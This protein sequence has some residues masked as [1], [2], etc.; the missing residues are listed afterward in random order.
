MTVQQAFELAARHQRCGQWTEAEALYRQILAVAPSHADSH[1]N[2][3]ILCAGQERLDE[4]VAAFRRAVQIRPDY[5]DAWNNLGGA[6]KKKRDLDG[7]TAAFEKALEIEP[8]HVEARSNLGATLTE[9]GRLE[10]GIAA[11]RRAVQ[12]GGK[13]PEC[14]NNLAI[15]LTEHGEFDEAATAYRRALQLKPDYAEARFNYALLLLLRGEYEDGWRCYESRWDRTPG[16][17]FGCPP[18]DGTPLDDRCI[19]VHAEQGFGD[20]IQFIRYATLLADFG[21]RVIVEC[22]KPLVRLFREVKGVMEAV[23]FGQPLPA[24]E[25]HAPMH[26]LPF[27]FRTRLEN[28]PANVPYLSTPAGERVA[29]E[30]RLGPAGS[31]LR[32]GLAWAGNPE[33]RWTQKRDLPLNRLLPLF[34]V[35]GIDFYSLQLA[36]AADQ[37]RLTPGA[38]AIRDC[39]GQLG[40]FRDTAAL[41]AHLDLVITVETA[42]AHLAGALALP[43]WT[44]LPFVPAWR[45][46]LERNDSPWYPTMRLFRQPALGDWGSVIE[47]VTNELADF[48]LRHHSP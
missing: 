39:S 18:W 33:N 19:L 11:H 30:G 38:G 36:P 40:D 10:E 4:A 45:W 25:V 6:L 1:N 23:A 17:N 37:L 47:R 7:A 35:E 15:A 42:V 44:L 8:G 28:I 21:G 12:L 3:G 2:L 41:M 13:Y 22:Q 29:W 20:S 31:R 9:Q 14:Y 16:R 27:L 24:F 46:G 48:K 5:A 26:S 43:V 32:I 34:Q